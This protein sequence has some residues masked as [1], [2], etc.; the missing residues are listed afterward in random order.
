MIK[1][2]LSISLLTLCISTTLLAKTPEK[3]CITPNATGYAANGNYKF[4]I[5]KIKNPNFWRKDIV[6]FL[7]KKKAP[8][9]FFSHGYGANDWEKFYSELLTYLASHGYNVVFVPYKS[10]APAAKRYKTLREGF[11][12]AANSRFKRFFDLTKVGYFGHSFGGGATPSMVLNGVKKH[13]WGSNKLFLYLSAPWYSLEI[14]NDELKQLPKNAHMIMQVYDLDDV[15]DHRMAIHLYKNIGISNEKKSYE[16]VHS[17]KSN[18][19][20][21]IVGHRYPTN[22]TSIIYHKRYGLFQSVGALADYVFNDSTK[23]KEVAFGKGKAFSFAGKM[24]NG[25]EFTPKTST[26]NPRPTQS[27]CFYKFPWQHKNNPKSKSRKKIR[28][29]K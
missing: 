1:R 5:K 13:G 22:E 8:V 23:A 12:A 3:K 20:N 14:S 6:L 21:V 18:R 16:T 4:Q 2:T 25:D 27:Q 26:K 28:C 7:Q 29:R 11:V 10:L 19:C 17:Y 9:I 24:D 15:N